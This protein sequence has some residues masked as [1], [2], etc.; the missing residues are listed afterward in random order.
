MLPN[1]DFK[2]LSLL[3]W[4]CSF[5]VVLYHYVW[6]FEIDNFK[7]N[8]II[9]YLVVRQ[10]YG[11]NF[12]W[13]YW[14]I[15]GFIFTYIVLNK[16]KILFKNFFLEIFRRFY[17]LQILT[18]L[19]ICLIQFVSFNLN[20]TTQL[21]Y[22]NNFYHFFLHL[23]FASD[24][25]FHENFSFNAPVW[26]MSILIPIY[27]FAFLTKNYLI[28]LKSIFGILVIS[29]T[30]FFI[31]LF[32][33]IFFSKLDL[34]NKWQYLALFNFK[35]CFFY[36]YFGSIIYFILN[37]IWSS[38]ILKIDNLIST[39]SFVTICCSIYFLNFNENKIF[40]YFPNTI[41]LFLGLIVFFSN[42]DYIT[43]FSF[44]RIHI[45]N[46]TSFSIYLWHFPFQLSLLTFLD[47]FNKDIIIFRSIYIF[48][49]YILILIIISSL[50]Y[51]YY[52]KPFRKKIKSYIKY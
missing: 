25:G 34:F 52:E 44:Y 20:G 48:L 36:F 42:L 10:E 8:S 50:S 35:Q 45:I 41:L 24:W 14:A 3:S 5:V 51:Y 21:D 16:K 28:K 33:D 1:K 19:Y 30:F 31:P 38:N 26:F 40:E 22:K 12:V 15:S 2:F 46:K 43:N 29:L 47:Y 13:L 9:N 32:Y 4:I 39:V 18:L 6:F 7:S 23:F 49:L 17:P 11:A 27:L 37:S